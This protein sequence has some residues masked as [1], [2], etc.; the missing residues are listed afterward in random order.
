MKRVVFQLANIVTEKVEIKKGRNTLIGT[1][2]VYEP[3]KDAVF[4][5][6][7]GMLPTYKQIIKPIWG[8][9]TKDVMVVKD[10]KGKGIV[11][12]R[13]NSLARIV[14]NNKQ[15]L[16]LTY[17]EGDRQVTEDTDFKNFLTTL[18]I[19]LPVGTS[20]TKKDV[21]AKKGKSKALVAKKK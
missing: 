10:S 13:F 19:N 11:G 12:V 5:S 21:V 4:I 17:E 3:V 2:E 16:L 6:K 8:G 15:H 9:M 18:A 7:L 14:L 1:R 20:V